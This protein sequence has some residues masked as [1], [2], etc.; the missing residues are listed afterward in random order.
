MPEFSAKSS[1]GLPAPQVPSVGRMVRYRSYGT[2]GGE[3]EPEDR[4]AII[5]E[6][7]P[8]G[9]ESAAQQCVALCVVNPTGMFFHTSVP[10]SET[11]KA[12][13]WSWP[14]RA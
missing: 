10:F 4:A 5:T 7:P 8:E 6:V 3:Y 14:P 2:P 13:H 9:T 11:P 1:P 12:G